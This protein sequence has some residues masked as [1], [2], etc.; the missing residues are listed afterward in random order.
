M[1]TTRTVKSPEV[2]LKETELGVSIKMLFMAG[3]NQDILFAPRHIF[4]LLLW[5]NIFILACKYHPDQTLGYFLPASF[6]PSYLLVQESANC[7]RWAKMNLH[8]FS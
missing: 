2:L 1:N 3:S 5:K 6:H 8:L 4:S 7:G